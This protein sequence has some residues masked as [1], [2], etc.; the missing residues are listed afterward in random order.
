VAASGEGVTRRHKISPYAGLEKGCTVG[1][2]YLSVGGACFWS[3]F[4]PYD[5]THQM[6]YRQARVRG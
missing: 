4:D 2:R 1:W 6:E 3:I 5:L